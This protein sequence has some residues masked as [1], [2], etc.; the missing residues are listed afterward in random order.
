[1][2]HHGRPSTDVLRDASISPLARLLYT[3][4]TTYATRD[5][6]CRVSRARLAADMGK[7][8]R[9]VSRWLTE[10]EESGVITRSEL[11]GGVTVFTLAANRIEVETRDTSGTPRDTS[12][13]GGETPVAHPRDTSGTR[14]SDSSVEDQGKGVG[15]AHV[16]VPGNP[17]D[18]HNPHTHPPDEDAV[19]G[20]AAKSGHD[21]G[22]AWTLAQHWAAQSWHRDSGIPI[23][24]WQLAINSK[25][26]SNRTRGKHGKSSGNSRQ[27]TDRSQSSYERRMQYRPSDAARSREA[28]IRKYGGDT[29][30]G[31]DDRER[32]QL[33]D[34]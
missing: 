23:T 26:E 16:R 21:P 5:L 9:S 20:F 10:L 27:A 24:N 29:G 33:P 8:V 25:L 28:L 7:S 15:S 4:L 34:G 14:I 6:I 18:P 3:V 11:T 22:D 31:T 30:A 1:M 12:G 32:G 19:K 13:K 2:M 17:E